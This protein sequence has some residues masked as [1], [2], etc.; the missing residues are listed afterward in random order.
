MTASQ[1]MTMIIAAIRLKSLCDAQIT[2]ALARYAELRPPDKAG[3]ELADD[4]RKQVA[5]ELAISPRVVDTKV[6]KSRKLV[7]RLPGTL[8]ALADGDID[9]R[10]AVA[11]VDLT[12][13]LS[14]EDAIRVEQDVL[15]AGGRVNYRRFRDA[16]RQRVIE[17]EAEAAE[18]RR[19]EAL[20]NPDVS[21]EPTVEGMSRLTADLA[22]EDAIAAR[23]RIDHLAEI[24]RTPGD[25]RT[26]GQRRV[27]V[28]TDLMLGH[29]GTDPI[30]TA[31]DGS[32][33]LTAHAGLNETSGEPAIPTAVAAGQNGEVAAE[34]RLSPECGP[35][36]SAGQVLDISRHRYAVSVDSPVRCEVPGCRADVVASWGDAAV[37]RTDDAESGVGATPVRTTCAHH[38]V[39]RQGSSWTVTESAPGVFT[40]VSEDG[41]RFAAVPERY[42][43]PP[44]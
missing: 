26:D 37:R 6:R 3:M 16:V 20:R 38:S 28:L 10:R 44:A 8:S 29:R 32:V 41:R 27:A 39:G 21:I 23:K 36:V 2:K 12:G 14:D 43:D 18:R 1:C 42:L 13:G 19:L 40:F 9:L 17:A 31:I 11:M 25:G 34:A 30:G 33:S 35:P 24:A 7:T 22:E 4:A 5:V 15:A